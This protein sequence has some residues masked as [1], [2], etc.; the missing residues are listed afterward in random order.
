MRDGDIAVY[1]SEQ[2][3]NSKHTTAQT[4]IYALVATFFNLITLEKSVDL[5]VEEVR[6]ELVADLPIV[7][8]SIIHKGCC[9]DLNQRYASAID[10]IED[11]EAS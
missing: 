9:T 5:F 11:L 8:Q 3:L 4:D 1:V 7:V 10:F 2:R 6:T